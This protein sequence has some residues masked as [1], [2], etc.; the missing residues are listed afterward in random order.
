MNDAIK[1]GKA[2]S[3]ITRVDQP[4][5]KGEQLHVHLGDKI[6]LNKDGTWKHGETTLTKAQVEWLRR[7]GWIIPK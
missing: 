1:K 5:V 4:K 2:P 3:G 6:A 7:N